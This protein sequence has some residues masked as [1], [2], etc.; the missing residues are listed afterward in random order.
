MNEEGEVKHFPSMKESAGLKPE[1]SGLQ[2]SAY[3]FLWREAPGSISIPPGWD[4]SPS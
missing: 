2:E 1:I 3:A 4:A